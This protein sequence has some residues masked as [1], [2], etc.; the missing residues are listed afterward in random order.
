V[1]R[2]RGG[3]A[4][5]GGGPSDIGLDEPSEPVGE[6]L[7]HAREQRGLDL[8][9]VHDRLARPITQIEAL[10][11]GDMAALPDQALALST[12]RR[13]ATFL[14]L[15][16]EALAEQFAESWEEVESDPSATRITPAVAGAAANTVTASPDHLRAFTET[17]EVPRVV[18]RGSSAG[19][20]S[21]GYDSLHS[22][23]PPT[24][25]FPVVPRSDLREGRR[26]VARARRRLRAPTYLKVLT[27]T[28]AALV[29]VVAIGF[30]MLA[31]TPR[32]LAKAHILRVVPVGSEGAANNPSGGG[33]RPP[34]RPSQQTFPV[35]PSGSTPTSASYTVATSKFVVVVAV[36]GPCWV[37]VTSSSSPTPLLSGVQPAA[38]VLTFPAIGAMTV[39]VGS[40]AVLVGITIKGKNAFTDAPK[41]VPFTYIFTPAP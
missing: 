13:Y 1:I 25:T 41:V 19:G 7:R 36:S 6:Q 39:E 32:T 5:R 24:G 21:G 33:S 16:G 22:T 4:R 15:D 20:S 23:G 3:A 12:L 40:S 37:Q 17:G 27:W 8:L 26:S 18:G 28:V 34:P 30:A 10:E 9:T 11:S 35:Q 38:K 29:L 31:T 14:D 2:P